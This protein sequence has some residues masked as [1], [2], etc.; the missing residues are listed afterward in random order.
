MKLERVGGETRV[1]GTDRTAL[2][3]GATGQ[4]VKIYGA[5]LGALRPRD[6]DLGPGLTVARVIETYAGCRDD[7]G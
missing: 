5:N 4:Q 3:Q 6:I 7:R 1:L 2:K